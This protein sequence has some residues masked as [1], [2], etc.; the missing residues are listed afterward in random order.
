MET[1]SIFV[2]KHDFT[3][4]ETLNRV[5]CGELKLASGRQIIERLTDLKTRLQELEPLRGE[6]LFNALFPEK[7]P[8]LTKS[9][10]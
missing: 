4:P 10:Q 6:E 5:Q 7:D 3:L 8:T 1:H 9:G 2:Y